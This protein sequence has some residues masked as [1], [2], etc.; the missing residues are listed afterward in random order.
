[1]TTQFRNAVAHFITDDGA[2][3]NLSSPVESN[4]YSNILYVSE[5]CVR[6]VVETHETWL[7]ELSA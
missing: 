5:L 3:L 2:V 4:R 1:M 6:T 7:R